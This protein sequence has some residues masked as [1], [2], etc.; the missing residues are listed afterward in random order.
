MGRSAA[1][2]RRVQS[3]PRY[4]RP[5]HGYGKAVGEARRRARVQ[6]RARE[7]NN[8]YFRHERRG[9]DIEEYLLQ[10]AI[11]N[12]DGEFTLAVPSGPGHLLVLGPTLDYVHIESSWGQLEYDRPGAKRY[13]PDGLVALDLKPGV[14]E[15]DV[16][17]TLRRGMTFRG[18]VLKPD[19][20]PVDKF[21]LLSR[22][23]LP[24]G[25]SWWNRLH[26]VEGRDGR[27]ELP[28]CDPQN[29]PTV[30][31]FD[32]KNELGATV[33]LSAKRGARWPGDDPP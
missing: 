11:S 19:G 20:N 33:R 9:G 12:A 6:Y 18:Q 22:S 31:L 25:Y 3:R 30:H 17:V 23:Y 14:K 13:Y 16:T 32:P 28:G 8:P 2:W 5:R 27:F 7:N 4:A 24:S 21:K 1:T 10:T 29:P 15:H 26:V